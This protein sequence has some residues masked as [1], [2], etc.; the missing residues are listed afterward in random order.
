M[1]STPLEYPLIDPRNEAELVEQ[2]IAYCYAVSNGTLNDF[3]SSSP[4]RVL[5][6]GQAFCMAELLYYCNKILE[7]LVVAYLSAFGVERRLGT[8]ATAQI[9]FT[10]SAGLQSPYVIPQGFIV[11]SRSGNV[12]FETT[13]LVV[14]PPGTIEA[15][16]PAICQQE[17]VIG[18][19]PEGLIDR[20]LQPLAYLKSAVNLQ[21][22]SGGSEE[23]TQED[24]IERGIAQI[25]RRNLV[26]AQDYEDQ[27]VE[28]LGVGSVAKAIGN[29]S[30]DKSSFQRGSVHVFCLDAAGNPPNVATVS[31]LNESMKSRIMV[32]SVLWISGIT[33]I[34]VDVDIVAKMLPGDDSRDVAE[35][36]WN[37]VKEFLAPTSFPVGR[38]LILNELEFAMRSTAR[39][40]YI[41]SIKIN[42]Y[43]AN[44]LVQNEFSMPKAYSM[45]ARLVDE[46]G[47]ELF[48]IKGAGENY[49]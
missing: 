13:A 25:R 19:I 41:D 20:I 47:N 48:H 15:S 35:V 38:D 36:L 1:T 45:F 42:G 18:N 34:N 21:P 37:A 16:C 31:Q 27:V 17:G 29:L 30:A 26:S 5:I 32:G 24:A 7:G 14:F 9:T 22:S 40:A 3:S 8:A 33:Q 4:L 46:D 44:L 39:A 2:A 11:A 23:E 43:G 49:L 6:E 12:S 28:I 10:L